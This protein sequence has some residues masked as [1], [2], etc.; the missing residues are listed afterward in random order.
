[1][2]IQYKVFLL[3]TV[4]LGLAL[5]SIAFQEMFDHGWLTRPQA[6]VLAFVVSVWT[7][8]ALGVAASDV[9]DST[10]KR[11]R[12]HPPGAMLIAAGIIVG[13]ALLARNGAPEP[14]YAEAVEIGAVVGAIPALEFVIWAEPVEKRLARVQAALEERGVIE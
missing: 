6:D 14:Y 9:V 11:F 10:F 1:M 7:V 13:F 8:V 3:G 12:P 4:M 5:A 2:K